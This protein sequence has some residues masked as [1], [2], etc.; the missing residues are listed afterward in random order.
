MLDWQAGG[1]AAAAVRPLLLFLH[2]AAA[3]NVQTTVNSKVPTG[4]SQQV[5]NVKI[6]DKWKSNVCRRAWL[7][8]RWHT[9]A[10][11]LST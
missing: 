6:L 1:M 10:T 9:V 8:G 3:Y 11:V 4:A 5:G 7:A 2:L